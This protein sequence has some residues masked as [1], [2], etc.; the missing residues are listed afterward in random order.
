MVVRMRDDPHGNLVL[1]V[2]SF[3]ITVTVVIVV[4]VVVVVVFVFVVVVVVADC[5]ITNLA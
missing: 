4:V 5:W 2:S 1:L 3:R